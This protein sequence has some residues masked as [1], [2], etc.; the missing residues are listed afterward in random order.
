MFYSHKNILAKINSEVI[1]ANQLDLNTSADLSPLYLDGQRHSFSYFPNGA[2]NGSFR[3]TYF[4]TGNDVIKQYL[5]DD[6]YV[7][8]GNI[9]GLYFNSGYVRSYSASFQPNS[10]IQ[11]N[12]EILVVDALMGQFLPSNIENPNPNYL[13]ASDSI[14]TNYT[15]FVDIGSP[16]QATYNYTSE[17]NP[18]F[19]QATGTGLLEITPSRVIFG[20]KQVSME[21]VSDSTGMFLP[22]DGQTCS[23]R[24]E[25]ANSGGLVMEVF[26]VTGKINSRNLNT[27]ISSPMNQRFEVIQHRIASNPTITSFSPSSVSAGST[28]TIL[29]TNFK[30]VLNVYINNEPASSYQVIS[31]TRIDTVI[32]PNQNSGYIK[33][34]TFEDNTY[35]NTRIPI[36]YPSINVD[37]FAP[38]NII[39]GNTVYINGSNFYKISRVLFNDR[40]ASFSIL[41]PNIIA[42]VSPGRELNGPISVISDSRYKSGV[43]SSNFYAKPVID[44][45]YPTTGIPGDIITVSGAN[46]S[47]IFLTYINDIYA[48]YSVINTGVIQLTVPNGD[49]RGYVKIINNGFQITTSKYDFSPQL[50]ITGLSI[51]SGQ[52]FSSLTISGVNFEDYMMY[53]LGDDSYKVSFNGQVTGF[54]RIDGQTLTGIVPRDAVTGPFY[55]FKSDSTS[56]YDSTG[57]FIYIPDAPIITSSYPITITSGDK[58]TELIVGT[59]LTNLT[60]V[61]LVGSGASANGRSIIIWDKAY[62]VNSKPADTTG[63]QYLISTAQND[64][65]GLASTFQHTLSAP[66]SYSGNTLLTGQAIRTGMYDLVVEN[67]AGTGYLSGALVINPLTNLAQSASTRIT[68]T[69][70]YPSGDTNTYNEY[71]TVDNN[72]GTYC[73]TNTVT[74]Q[75]MKFSFPS[76]CQIFNINL[77]THS[78]GY[79]LGTTGY[80]EISLLT[81]TGIGTGIVSS[82]LAN[83]SPYTTLNS[84]YGINTGTLSWR[85]EANAV[86][87]RVNR[88]NESGQDLPYPLVLSNVEI[89]G[90]KMNRS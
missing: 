17:I 63:V 56:T 38:T 45:F 28:L 86:L 54:S 84:G 76:K 4:L 15:P 70:T 10:P 9:G 46:F 44:S 36:N 20:K 22:I 13:N 78:T 71:K 87:I 62:N 26:S 5:D 58:L 3:L 48:P 27:S 8:S 7:L 35:S 11:V 34:D 52:A 43:S 74:G 21:I 55:I 60:K 53:N 47:N 18:I 57:D 30:N 2:V 24:L 80:L 31:D 42:A 68:I 59:N 49:T 67:I 29:G 14:F 33:V 64:L 85:N 6:D 90:I 82:G 39:S 16:I 40:E 25:A 75:W 66:S 69:S 89:L 83:I 79:T 50:F 72:T 12:A 77:T 51:K 41:N 88:R 81:G 32:A 19:Y 1:L 65:L 61:S 23:L 37:S 73:R